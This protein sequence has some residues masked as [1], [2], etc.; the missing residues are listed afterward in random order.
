MLKNKIKL[1]KENLKET[2]DVFAAKFLEK[3]LSKYYFARMSRADDPDKALADIYRKLIRYA[4]RVVSKIEKVEK[5]LVER[6]IEVY[7]PE[8][9]EKIHL[10]KDGEIHIFNMKTQKDWKRAYEQE[11]IEDDNS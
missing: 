5:E 7:F 9:S 6:K 1:W 3:N 10:G 8:D 2:K 11:V 4:Q